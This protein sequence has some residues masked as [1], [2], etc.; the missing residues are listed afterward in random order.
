MNGDENKKNYSHQNGTRSDLYTPHLEDWANMRH[1]KFGK[2]KRTTLNDPEEVKVLAQ[3]FPKPKPIGKKHALNKY[4][5]FIRN[6]SC[7]CTMSDF[8]KFGLIFAGQ[9]TA[10]LKG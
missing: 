7:F 5:Q 1:K 10:C 6:T 9:C 4:E 8:H 3:S 2:L